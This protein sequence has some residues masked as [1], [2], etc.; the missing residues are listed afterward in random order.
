MRFT[1]PWCEISLPNNGGNAYGVKK[2]TIQ[3]DPK[4]TVIF[5]NQF[6]CKTHLGPIYLQTTLLKTR[7]ENTLF[8]H[9]MVDFLTP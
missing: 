3:G 1:L 9:F 4:Q 8:P 2:S 5:E 6:F 7:F